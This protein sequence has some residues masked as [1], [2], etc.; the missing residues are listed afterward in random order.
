MVLSL[1]EEAAMTYNRLLIVVLTIML[2]M[3]AAPA[4]PEDE[5]FDTAASSKHM[6]QGISFLKAK[7]FDAAINEFTES[8]SI[9]PEAEAYY[10]LGYAYYMK[11]R[12]VGGDSR[13]LSME[14]FEKAYEI[15]PHFSPTRY[16]PSEP[17]PQLT[18]RSSTTAVPV[19][20]QPAAQQPPA[21]EQPKP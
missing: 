16:K 12:K 14:N 11:G 3:V 15:D 5:L 2:S 19:E 9:A 20:P 1:R 6:E 21:P 18:T 4:F 8:A 13:K 17:A 10:Y 7:D